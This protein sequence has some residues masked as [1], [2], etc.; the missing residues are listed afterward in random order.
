MKWNASSSCSFSRVG[1]VHP[2]GRYCGASG[3]VT[4]YRTFSIAIPEETRVF[5]RV[6][7]FFAPLFFWPALKPVCRLSLMNYLFPPLRLRF[8]IRPAFSPCS[9]PHVA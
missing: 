7:F 5:I 6:I 3:P 9:F 4:F 8:P 1:F 2:L